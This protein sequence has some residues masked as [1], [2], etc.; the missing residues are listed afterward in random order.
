MDRP[1][2]YKV[3]CFRLPKFVHEAA[4]LRQEA[5]FASIQYWSPT[6]AFKLMAYRQTQEPNCGVGFHAT[7]ILNFIIDSFSVVSWI[8]GLPEFLSHDRR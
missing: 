3:H 4:C 6:V 7:V 5:L 8:H 2:Q 1:D